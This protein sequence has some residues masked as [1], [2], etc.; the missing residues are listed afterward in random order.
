MKQGN[1]TSI[2]FFRHVNDS[3]NP[4]RWI[5]SLVVA[6]VVALLFS[7]IALNSQMESDRELLAGLSPYLTTLVE[8]FDRPE[9]LRV[10]SSVSEVKKSEVILVQEGRV[11][12]TSRGISELDLPYE[13]PIATYKFF[14]SDFL[15]P[16]A[17]VV[18]T[19]VITIPG[20]AIHNAYLHIISPLLPAIKNTMHIFLLTFVASMVI[21]LYSARQMR[22]AIKKTLR[23]LEQLHGEIR[24]LISLNK[25]QESKP[26]SIRELEEIRKT[27]F[28]TKIDLENANDR[29]AEIKAKKLNAESYKRLIHDLHNPVAALRQMT[30]FINDPNLNEE[31][32][33]EVSNTVSRTAE[34][35]LN[36]VTA[37]RKNLDD[38]PLILRELDL[39]DCISECVQQNNIVMTN[40]KKILCDFPTEK[41]M[42]AHDP[43]LLKRALTNLIENAVEYSLSLV[44]ISV[45][46]L[47]EY[48]SIQVSDDGPGM[49]EENIT[50]FFQG[51]GNSNKAKRQAYGLSSTN[52]IVRTHGGKLIYRTSEFGGANFEIRLGAIIL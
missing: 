25:E 45:T 12:A 29:L 35:I 28:E 44:K 9:M 38:E 34:Q 8:S 33:N 37:A 43:A 42:A 6:T 19:Q 27:V 7:L 32:K 13:K 40:S 49:K 23:P 46:K 20:H 2:S 52:H 30:K 15:F 50:L 41:V 14:N 11:L 10:I 36:Q 5:M 4:Y 1:Q 22:K 39:R 48:I 31:E 21:A 47:G 26:I 16:S 17:Q 18:S 3:I 24:G 51:R